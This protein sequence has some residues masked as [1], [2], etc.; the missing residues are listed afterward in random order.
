METI[1]F[2][3]YVLSLKDETQR[4][5]Q[6]TN[7]LKELYI[8]FTFY[9]AVDLRKSDRE[10][11]DKLYSSIRSQ[12]YLGRNLTNGEIGCALS[13]INICEK[14][15]ASDK[16]WALVIEDDAILGRLNKDIINEIIMTPSPFEIFILGYSKVLE[17]DEKNYYW[18]FPIKQKAKLNTGILGIPYSQWACGTVAYLINRSGAKKIIEQFIKEG[19]KVSTVADDW[20]YLEKICNVAIAHYRPILVFENFL[21][22]ESSLELEREKVNKNCLPKN[23]VV[24]FIRN[25]KGLLRKILLVFK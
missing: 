22:L 2:N 8:P 4:R 7:Q 10:S 24:S 9:D 13:H 12:K 19:R 3:T 18:R 23:K 25:I 5:T 11:I 20:S 17:K 1:R 14:F 21:N 16:D 6:I 15:L